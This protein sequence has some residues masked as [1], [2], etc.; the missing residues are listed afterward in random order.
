M[1]ALGLAPK[2]GVKPF[3]DAEEG[4]D[5]VEVAWVGPFHA[6]CCVVELHG[7]LQILFAFLGAVAVVFVIIELWREGYDTLRILGGVVFLLVC[8]YLV[9]LSK[10]IYLIKAFRK[11]ID[12]FRGLNEQLGGEVQKL[13]A[14]NQSYDIKN[15]DQARLNTELSDKVSDLSRVEQQL[16]VLSAECQG[17]VQQARQVVERLE[18]NLQLNTVNSAFLFF[19]RADTNKNGKIDGDE[20]SQFVDSLAFLWQH[21]P[22]FDPER[23]KAAII[24]QGGI[25]MEQVQKLVDAMMLDMESVDPAELAKRV[26]DAL[27]V[28][29]TN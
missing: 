5:E 29:E 14:E 2:G 1:Q 8:L 24:K 4:E 23:M 18:R 25:S 22:H 21:L 17:S 11:E 6:G 16:S 3:K 15:R 20:V 27:V 28:T 7:P 12:K 19:D 13:Q 26:E 9:W 10:A